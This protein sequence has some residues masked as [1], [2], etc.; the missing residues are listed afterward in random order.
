[1]LGIGDGVVLDHA[2]EANQVV[3]G[4]VKG[5]GEQHGAIGQHAGHPAMADKH[6]PLAGAPTVIT[7]GEAVYLIML[8][9]DGQFA[10]DPPGHLHV[11]GS[12]VVGHGAL[13]RVD[14]HRGM[15]I[16]DM[17]LCANVLVVDPPYR[18]VGVFEDASVVATVEGASGTVTFAQRQSVVT[19]E[20][21]LGREHV[22]PE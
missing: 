13:F 18:V 10:A 19:L 7:E 2:A 4:A 21:V 5:L 11:V 17:Q 15:V 3:V 14:I 16:L 9:H 22:V 20:D 6:I 1:M 8:A 12:D